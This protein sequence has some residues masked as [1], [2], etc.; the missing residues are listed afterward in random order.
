MNNHPNDHTIEQ[1]PIDELIAHCKVPHFQRDTN[2]TR[3]QAIVEYEEEYYHKNANQFSFLGVI[4]L[5]YLSDLETTIQE[6]DWYIVDG[7]HRFCAMRKLRELEYP[8]F[9]VWVQWKKSDT[10]EDM[11]DLFRRMNNHVEV[12]EYILK[13]SINERNIYDD[14]RKYFTRK[15]SIYLSDNKKCRSPNLHLDT[16][17]DEIH[18]SNIIYRKMIT[19]TSQLVHYIETW[20][21]YYLNELREKDNDKFMKIVQKTKTKHAYSILK[22]IGALPEYFAFG[23]IRDNDWLYN[24]SIPII[25]NSYDDVQFQLSEEF[26]SMV[27]SYLADENGILVNNDVIVIPQKRKTIPPM[28]KQKVWL[29]YMGNV[30]VGECYVC[31]SQL[32]YENCEMG[33]VLSIHNGGTDDE[34]NLRPICGSCNKSM[35]VNNLEEYKTFHY[36]SL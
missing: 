2:L 6:K 16:F 22:K 33:H 27:N 14:L 31:N 26:I 36:P 5:S 9:T 21:Q 28:K 34:T 4:L 32:E 3:I 19:Q 8:N 23:F 1:I 10:M 17:I 15:Y 18:D 13:C 20:N 7:Q 12:P 24:D 35:G 11:L 29:T 25:P 30:L